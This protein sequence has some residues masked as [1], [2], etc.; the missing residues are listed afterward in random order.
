MMCLSNEVVGW[1]RTSYMSS[2]GV[3]DC[4]RD[5]AKGA[6]DSSGLSSMN[7][8]GHGMDMCADGSAKSDR[9]ATLKEL[10]RSSVRTSTWT[11]YGN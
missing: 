6:T 11:S 7:F 10:A 4:S 5:R 3:E 9:S 2:D 1:F 8:A